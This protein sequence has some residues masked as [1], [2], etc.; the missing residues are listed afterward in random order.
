MV[1]FLSRD[2]ITNRRAWRLAFVDKRFGDG[3][4]GAVV[5]RIRSFKLT[6]AQHASTCSFPTV[7]Q[8]D[9]QAS[10]QLNFGIKVSQAYISRLLMR[11]RIA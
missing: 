5:R 1:N 2:P 6:D 7:T 10:I 9:I 11:N 8:N 4:N 3:E